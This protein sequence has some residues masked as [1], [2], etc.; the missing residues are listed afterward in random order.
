MKTKHW[1]RV[2]SDG[3]IYRVSP[4]NLPATAKPGDLVWIFYSGMQMRG[5]VVK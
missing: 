1:L 2:E 5:K 4:S 3:R